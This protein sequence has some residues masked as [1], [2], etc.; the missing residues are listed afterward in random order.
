MSQ[1]TPSKIIVFSIAFS[2]FV[3]HEFTPGIL[4]ESKQGG[5]GDDEIFWKEVY[6]Y[7]WLPFSHLFSQNGNKYAT[8]E[9]ATYKK[10]DMR[11]NA[12]SIIFYTFLS[13]LFFSFFFVKF[14]RQQKYP[15]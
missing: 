11:E 2:L 5:G 3:T 14:E 4:R 9:C 1:Y 8:W 6:E 15:H 13:D 7:K 12:L 10:I